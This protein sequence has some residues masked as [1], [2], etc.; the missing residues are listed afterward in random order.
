MFLLFIVGFYFLADFAVIAL[1]TTFSL[2][3]KIML[4]VPPCFIRVCHIPSP[5]QNLSRGED[6][7]TFNSR[8]T[9]KQTD[10]V[11][12]PYPKYED[13]DQYTGGSP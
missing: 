6:K 5:L 10:G 7:K 1:V 4:A 11:E 8:L 12:I 13:S 2:L 3:V 9:I